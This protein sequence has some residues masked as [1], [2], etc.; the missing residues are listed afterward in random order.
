MCAKSLPCAMSELRYVSGCFWNTIVV[1][2]CLQYQHRTRRT[3]RK[4]QTLLCIPNHSYSN[5]SSS[6]EPTHGFVERRFYVAY[7]TD[8]LNPYIHLWTLVNNERVIEATVDIFLLF[9]LPVHYIYYIVYRPTHNPGTKIRSSAG[10]PHT[11]VDIK[12]ELWPN[13]SLSVTHSSIVYNT[14]FQGR[15]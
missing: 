1:S 10:H 11:A 15:P 6:T 14:M 9:C 4:M 3:P 7:I 13:G 5:L 2:T 12:L 8:I